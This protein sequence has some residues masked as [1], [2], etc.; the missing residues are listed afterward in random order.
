MTHSLR[1]VWRRVF[2]EA[3]ILVLVLLAMLVL[4]RAYVQL[5]APEAGAVLLLLFLVMW[6]LPFVCFDKAGRAAM[7]LVR[8]ARP[9]W[10]LWGGLLGF[11]A[12][13]LVFGIGYGLYGDS[14]DNWYVSVRDHYLTGQP[15]PEMPRFTL[16]LMFTIPAM[17]FS[18]V[19]E[20]FFFRGMLHESV[21]EKW[22]G[23]AAVAVNSLAFAGVHIL[24]HGIAA[25]AAGLEIRWISGLLWVALMAALSV[26][27]T[28]CRLR[29]GS[30]WPAVLA[31]STFN[32]GMNVTIFYILL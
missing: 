12:A 28:L 24:H 15:V 9:V 6:V 30:I 17:L 3:W 2:G 10:L 8:S 7:G 29:G 5:Q 16:F 27:F 4:P 31:H 23:Q 25:D 1:S 18:P 11:A 32:L 20:E 13:L 21:R 14:P 19:G 22:G 26:L